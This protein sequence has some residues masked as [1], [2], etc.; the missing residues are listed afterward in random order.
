MEACGNAVKKTKPVVI[1][2]LMVVNGK[3]KSSVIASNNTV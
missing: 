3:K 2:L 1:G